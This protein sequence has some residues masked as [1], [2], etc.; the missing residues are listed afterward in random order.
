MSR[1]PKARSVSSTAGW[2]SSALRTSERMKTA[3][4]PSFTILSATA[5]PRFS[6]RP[7]IVTLAPS[8]AK[9][10]AVASP[11]PDVPPVISAT[12]F[13]NR[14]FFN[15]T[16]PDLRRPPLAPPR[17]QRTL[18]HWRGTVLRGRFLPACRRDP[19]DAWPNRTEIDLRSL[20]FAVPRF[21]ALPYRCH[22]R[23]CSLRE[24]SVGRGQWPC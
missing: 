3:L 2:Q 21:A 6:S 10:A 9:S 20:L 14:I 24:S 7:V 12:L 17:S 22:P 4:P 19:E 15:P 5:C 18:H 16:P 13:S 11:M 1:P 23:R 8:L